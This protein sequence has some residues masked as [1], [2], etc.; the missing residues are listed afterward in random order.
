MINRRPT[1]PEFVRLARASVT[2]GGKRS[3]Q[4]AAR[5]R[6]GETMSRDYDGGGCAPPTDV[7]THVEP[8]G[9]RPERPLRADV[10][11]PQSVASAVDV[12]NADVAC[13]GIGDVDGVGVP[14]AAA[15]APVVSEVDV[16]GEYAP[17]AR[18]R[19]RTWR[20]GIVPTPR[21]RIP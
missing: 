21:S 11:A 8:L 2:V 14:L 6:V 20:L 12:R 18:H 10:V 9:I 1:R 19:A 5:L 17:G 13:A 16:I 15:Q 7:V 3:S 4:R